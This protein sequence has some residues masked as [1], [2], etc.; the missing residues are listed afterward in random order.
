MNLLLSLTCGQCWNQV[1]SLVLILS[2]KIPFFDFEDWAITTEALDVKGE[3]R[4]WQGL[5]F[6]ERSYG[7]AL[8]PLE[9]LCELSGTFHVVRDVPGMYILYTYISTH[10][11]VLSHFLAK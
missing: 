5:S 6:F 1:A 3:D 7:Q 10:V 11:A 8:H 4:N 2:F 9:S